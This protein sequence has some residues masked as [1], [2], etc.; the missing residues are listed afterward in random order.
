MRGRRQALAWA[1]GRVL[2]HERRK[3]G[4]SQEGLAFAAEI[5]RTYPS[6]IESGIRA[7]TIE[8]IFA[9]SKAL[10]LAPGALM[11]KTSEFLAR[12]AKSAAPP[13]LTAPASKV[14]RKVESRQGTHS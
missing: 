1:F 14:S 13:P 3:A 6:K 8:V 12:R 2:K 4:L 10:G 11:R 9:L 7:P 5:D